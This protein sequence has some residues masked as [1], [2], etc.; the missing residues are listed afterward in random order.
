MK[1]CILSAIGYDIANIGKQYIVVKNNNSS[2]FFNIRN[3]ILRT[4]AIANITGTAIL[5]ILIVVLSDFNKLLY[6][7]LLENVF[8]PNIQ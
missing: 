5:N 8:I 2:S 6:D 3:T 7:I 1:K 4:I